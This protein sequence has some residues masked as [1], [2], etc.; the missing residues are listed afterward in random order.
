MITR[1][2]GQSA[3]GF[4]V[5]LEEEEKLNGGEHLSETIGWL[6][7]DPGSAVNG[8][9]SLLS[10]TTGLVHNHNVSTVNFGETF[11]A[12][13]AVIAKLASF[14]SPN[15]ANVRINSITSSGFDVN[16]DEEQSLD[17]ETNHIKESVSF[18]ALEGSSGTITGINS[19]ELNPLSTGG[20]DILTGTVQSDF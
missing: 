16:V 13:P 18:L 2:T 1:T 17:S 4:Q 6:A 15:T 8:D 19:Q 3:T 5:A 7:M 11:D 14:Y 10:G 12:A 9:T 20:S